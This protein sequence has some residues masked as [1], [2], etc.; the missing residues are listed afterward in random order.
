[1][2]ISLATS[3]HVPR[4]VVDLL[5]VQPAE[6][7]APFLFSSP[8]LTKEDAGMI[9]ATQDTV[10]GATPG[11]QCPDSALRAKS[12]RSHGRSRQQ[13][14]DA[15]QPPLQSAAAVRD[16]LRALVRTK[17]RRPLAAASPTPKTPPVDASQ[18]SG[19]A[20]TAAALLREARAGNADRALGSI[21]ASLK[22]QADTIEKLATDGDGRLL[23]A[24]LKLLGLTVA[25]A[26]TV[27][28]M[29]HR[30]AGR[31]VA[32][33]AQL[34]RHYEDLSVESCVAALGVSDH[35]ASA[36]GRT[37]PQ[38]L[39]QSLHAPESQRRPA[40]PGQQTVFGRRRKMPSATV[41]RS[42]R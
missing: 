30:T 13:K 23:A 22:L 32:A 8:C 40:A 12:A 27:L 25:D 36:P 2:A 15:A 18:P 16:A 31:D 41:A 14:D 5:L 29:V 11:R 38:A 20:A 39:H 6:F 42:G 26:M 9:G 21:A 33:F 10:P 24:A 7:S 3:P 4:P 28:M 17:P 35:P 19:L 1:M 37:T 34:R